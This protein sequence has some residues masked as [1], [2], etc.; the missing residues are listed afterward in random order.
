MASADPPSEGIHAGPALDLNIVVQRHAVV[1][2][3]QL[4]SE[5]SERVLNPLSGGRGHDTSASFTLDGEEN[6]RENHSSR[7]QPEHIRLGGL[8]NGIARAYFH[9]NSSSK[10]F[11]IL[12]C[13]RIKRN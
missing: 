2:R 13:S 5:P 8:P 7:A 3:G 10:I 1:Q 4:A 6:F 12:F 9:S 11:V